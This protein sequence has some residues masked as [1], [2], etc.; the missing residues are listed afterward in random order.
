MRTLDA[1]A[2]GSLDGCCAAR[3]RGAA[4]QVASFVFAGAAPHAAIL[5]RRH[6]ELETLLAHGA[7]GAQIGR[8]SC[9]ERV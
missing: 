1:H 2:E 4:A 9:R 8:A 5:V 6:R 7:V 3:G